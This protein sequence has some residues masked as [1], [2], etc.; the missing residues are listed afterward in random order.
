MASLQIEA[1]PSLR[2]R[3][4]TQIPQCLLL[5]NSRR[6]TQSTKRFLARY[7]MWFKLRNRTK[8]N[9]PRNTRNGTMRLS[10]PR[11][12]LLS[13]DKSVQLTCHCQDCM[14]KESFLKIS[15]GLAQGAT[16]KG[17]RLCASAKM[18]QV[19]NHASIVKEPTLSV[20][21]RFGSHTRS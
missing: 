10:L 9:F 18:R 12:I 3:A 17:I 7:M 13:K 21:G 8:S 19:Q 6:H 11:M 15:H 20:A 4:S 16:I 14:G 1:C 2:S 5:K